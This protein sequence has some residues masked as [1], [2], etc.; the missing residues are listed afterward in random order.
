MYLLEKDF[1]SNV[2]IIL[3]GFLFNVISVVATRFY[4][5]ILLPGNNVGTT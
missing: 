4:L 1:N 5:I 3:Y 2:F